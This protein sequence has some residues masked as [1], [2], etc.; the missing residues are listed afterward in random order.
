MLNNKLKSKINKILDDNYYT[1]K[2]HCFRITE[3][4]AWDNI[5]TLKSGYEILKDFFKEKGIPWKEFLDRMANEY[6]EAFMSDNYNQE[7][8]NALAAMQA[9]LSEKEY[10]ENE[11]D[12]SDYVADK[13]IVGLTYEQWNKILYENEEA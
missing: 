2:N 11:Q 1:D 10:S 3:T 8:T 7:H 12:I 13:I 5:Y 9:Y 4:S 6:A